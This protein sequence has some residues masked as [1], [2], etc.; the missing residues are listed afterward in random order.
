ML[1]AGQT[2]GVYEMRQDREPY[3]ILEALGLLTAGAVLGGII[4][5]MIY[6]GM[7]TGIKLELPIE[8]PI[9][10]SFWILIWPALGMVGALLLIN[11]GKRKI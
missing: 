1:Q 10:N 3:H 7:V 9:F 2:K 8:K 11:Q 6:V 5:G 4:W